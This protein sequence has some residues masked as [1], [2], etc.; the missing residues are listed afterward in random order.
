MAD[1]ATDIHTWVKNINKQANQT[2]QS[3]KSQQY[4]ES[5]LS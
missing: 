1:G 3:E 4:Q 2:K 5:I